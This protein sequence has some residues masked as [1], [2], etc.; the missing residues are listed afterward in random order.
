MPLYGYATF[1]LP[2]L[3][4]GYLSCFHFRGSMNN[5]VINIC[6]QLLCEYMF[7]ILLGIYVGVDLLSHAVTPYLIFPGADVSHSG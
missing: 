1:N 5:D 2:I 4:Y 3:V 6:V 7:S